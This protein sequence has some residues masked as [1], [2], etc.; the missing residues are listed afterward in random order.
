VIAVG[1][2][3]ENVGIFDYFTCLIPIKLAGALDGEY[4]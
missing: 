4:V 1:A 2:A 3:I